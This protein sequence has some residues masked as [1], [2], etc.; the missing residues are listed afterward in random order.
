MGKLR[1]LIFLKGFYF[2]IIYHCCRDS[3]CFT[4][5]PDRQGT[6]EYYKCI[7]TGSFKVKYHVSEI[8]IL[9]EFLKLE[10]TSAPLATQIDKQCR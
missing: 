7:K 9:K 10:S 8:F 5:H 2:L 1:V 4:V 3:L 6:L